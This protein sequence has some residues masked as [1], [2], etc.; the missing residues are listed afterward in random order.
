VEKGSL[1]WSALTT[2]MLLS[3]V[4]ATCGPKPMEAPSLGQ[5]PRM[6][7]PFC[8]MSGGFSVPTFHSH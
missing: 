6:D 4:L 8:Q 5:L 7:S 3:P 2:L 1:A